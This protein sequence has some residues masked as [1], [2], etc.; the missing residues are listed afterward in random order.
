MENET[1]FNINVY[2]GNKQKIDNADNSTQQY[3]IIMNEELQN[4]LRVLQ[5]ELNEMK[6]KND[7]LESESDKHENS[8]RY[9]RGVLKNFVEL[10][11]MEK[12]LGIQYKS[13]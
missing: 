8:I 12:E 3:I 11:N 7:E 6:S 5:Q 2:E 4:K 13:E 9:M 1:K 10:R